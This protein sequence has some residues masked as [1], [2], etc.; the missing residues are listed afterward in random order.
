MSQ[1]TVVFED[2]QE[3]KDF[4]RCLLDK[5]QGSQI[6]CC[7]DGQSTQAPVQAVPEQPL[8]YGQ[9][10][11]EHF[12]AANNSQVQQPAPAQP[13]VQQTPAQTPPVQQTVPTSASSYKLDDLASA[14][15]QLMDK[16]MQEQLQQLLVGYGVEALPQLPAEQYGNFATALR[17]MGAQ[18]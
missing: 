12:P 4:A 1:I 5:E 18:I 15:M 6:G 2:L 7:G 3:M 8:S 17:G 10:I 14:A 9:Q 11:A 13:V 16:G